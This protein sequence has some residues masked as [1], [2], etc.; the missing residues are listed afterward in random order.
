MGTPVSRRQLLATGVAG[1]IAAP[2]AAGRAAEGTAERAAPS[3]KPVH[4]AFRYCLNTATLRGQKL[5]ITEVVAIAHRAGYQGIEPWIDELDQLVAGGGSLKDL[6]KQLADSGLKVESAIGFAQ[7]CVDDPVERKKGLEEARR[8]MGLVAEI[9]GTRIAAPPAGA[10]EKKIESGVLGER[11]GALLELGDRMGVVPIAEIWGPSSTMSRLGEVAQ[12]AIDSGHANACILPDIYHLYKGGSGYTGL[13]LLAS[14]T[15]PVIHMND[16]PA[17]PG[18]SE[19]TDA[20]R[21][22]PGDGVAPWG[23]I[24]AAL[25]AMGFGGALSLE[26]FNRDYWQQDPLGIALT[27]LAKM[28]TVME[29]IA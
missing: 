3:A 15:V 25:R 11:Y 19:I 29:N 17:M 12:I 22:Y 16:Y 6:G 2:A 23:E 24:M 10:R 7:W 8:T 27:G 4:P 18:R 5:A 9:G 14:H 20:A 26:L 13:G 28:K 21:V 1:A